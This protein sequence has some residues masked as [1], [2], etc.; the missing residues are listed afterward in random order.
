MRQSRV[1]KIREIQGRYKQLCSLLSQPQLLSTR[2]EIQKYFQ[3]RKELEE[4]IT[5]WEEYQRNQNEIKKLKEIIDNKEEDKEIKILAEEEKREI[6]KKLD[7][8]EKKLDRLLFLKDKYSQRNIIVEIRAGAGGEEA[9]LFVADLYKMY[10]RFAEKKNWQVENIHFHPTDRGG[11]KEVIFGIKGKEAFS[12]LRY[13]SGVHRVQRIPITESS[14]RIHTS[15]ATVAI[16]PEAE[17]VEVEISPDD[18][19]IETFRSRGAGGQHVN[20]TDS[21]VRITHRPTQIVVQCQ[22]ERSQHQ[23]RVRA[24]RVLRAKLLQRK[25]EEQQ[26]KFSLQRKTQIGRG[27]RAERI[28]TYNFPQG[29]VTDH[30]I[31]LT[32]YN[33]EE[34]LNG[35]MDTLLNSLKEK[36]GVENVGDTG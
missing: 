6:N 27:E 13:E 34:I 33:L 28:R 21:A 7:A 9:S 8:L 2:R 3:E 11:F 35:E 30:R 4:I 31:R 18:L 5:L 1:D 36:L 29:R 20:V 14:G 26:K 25:E 10:I 17:E 16:L 32:L 15:T 19:V 22:D 12:F 23:N 24:M